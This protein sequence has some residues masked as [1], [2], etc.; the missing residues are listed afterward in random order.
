MYLKEKTKANSETET[1]TVLNI[2]SCSKM[3]KSTKNYWALLEKKLLQEV[4][5]V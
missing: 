4:T 3:H 1:Q 2:K 5:K